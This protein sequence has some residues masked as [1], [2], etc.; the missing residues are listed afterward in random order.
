M[1]SP[2]SSIARFP[3]PV[4]NPNAKMPLSFYRLQAAGGR[5]L[6]LDRIGYYFSGPYLRNLGAGILV[7]LNNETAADLIHL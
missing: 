4:A 5:N 1:L 6:T 7:G 2:F 3:L